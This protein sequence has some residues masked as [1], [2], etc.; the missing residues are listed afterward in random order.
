MTNEEYREFARKRAPRSQVLRN[1]LGAFWVGGLIC[2]LG[3]ALGRLFQSA[4]LEAEAA[5]TAASVTLVFLGAALTALGLY[6][7]LAKLGRAGTLVPIT[8]FANSMAAPALEFKTEGLIAGSCAK[9]FV[10]AG[11]V[12]VCGISASVVYGLLLCLLGGAP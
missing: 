9:M 6:D 4:G 7:R 12:I 8:G 11:P 3:E 10:I 1:C 2:C 5:G